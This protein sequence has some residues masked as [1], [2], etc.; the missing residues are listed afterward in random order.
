MKS[1]DILKYY[2]S[3][4]SIFPHGYRRVR[5]PTDE[6]DLRTP[7]ANYVRNG[8]FTQAP[9]PFESLHTRVPREQQ[10]WGRDSAIPGVNSDEI[11]STNPALM[12]E[13]HKL[14]KFLVRDVLGFD[15]MFEEPPNIRFHFPRGLTDGM[16]DRYRSSEGIVLA[17]HSDTLFGDPF[18][19]INCWIPLGTCFGSNALSGPRWN[20]VWNCFTHSVK[21]LTTVRNS[22][23]EK[24]APG[25]S[26]S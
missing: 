3:R 18:E 2:L 1:G 23:C 22:T 11:A 10:A 25:S 24:V 16:P 20:P 13:Y 7:L 12:A 5:Y 9:L 26:T 6:I 4:P 15:V 19:Q 14:V 21:R 17:Q 8:G